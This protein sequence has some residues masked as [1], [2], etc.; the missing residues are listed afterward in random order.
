M[1][2]LRCSSMAKSVQVFLAHISQQHMT[3]S[4]LSVAASQICGPEQVLQ[5]M[6][7]KAVVMLVKGQGGGGGAGPGQEEG[8]L[9]V[10][11]C[12][13]CV[14]IQGKEGRVSRLFC[15]S[16]LTDSCPIVC[17]NLRAAILG[18]I[19]A[20]AAH[21]TEGHTCLGQ[22]SQDLEQVC[23]TPSPQVLVGGPVSLSALLPG[24]PV[25]GSKSSPEVSTP[26]LL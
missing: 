7:R 22:R 21:I 11:V 16:A 24:F 9:H 2:P 14:S 23:L 18:N 1:G 20:K 10:T 15:H 8:V 13:A 4:P 19:T 5:G 6:V 12:L 3:S 26:W 25:P 17:P